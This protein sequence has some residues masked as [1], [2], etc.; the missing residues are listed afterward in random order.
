MTN[1]AVPARSPGRGGGAA[2]NLLR[3]AIAVGNRAAGNPLAITEGNV[4][5]T[6][7]DVG[8]ITI[9]ALNDGEVHLPPMYYP[10]LDFGAHPEL[11]QAGRAAPEP[12]TSQ[13]RDGLAG[14]GGP[15][16]AGPAARRLHLSRLSTIST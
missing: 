12:V 14:S 10:G 8:G 16:R 11:L 9:S 13:E 4:L 15:R 3:R 5:S 2:H 6:V 1:T 7:I